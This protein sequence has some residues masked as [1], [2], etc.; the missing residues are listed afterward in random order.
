MQWAMMLPN[1]CWCSF[2]HHY[3]FCLA[4]LCACLSLTSPFPVTNITSFRTVKWVWKDVPTKGA[5][6]SL[7]DQ[8][9]RIR[10]YHKTLVNLSWELDS[11]V[12]LSAGDP[13]VVII[14]SFYPDKVSGFKPSSALLDPGRGQ[15][16]SLGPFGWSIMS[17]D[18]WVHPQK[19]IQ[20]YLTCP[21]SH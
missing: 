5:S 4:L 17:L 20:V 10:V 18:G 19:I 2:I 16:T 14:P 11:C 1:Q 13:I 7:L 6:N 3:S 12:I 8:V 21:H 15:P 9:M